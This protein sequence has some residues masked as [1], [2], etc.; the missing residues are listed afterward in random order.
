MSSK[1]IHDSFWMANNH[2]SASQLSTTGTISTASNARVLALANII[3]GTYVATNCLHHLTNSFSS[4]GHP[5]LCSQK[6]ESH[7]LGSGGVRMYQNQMRWNSTIKYSLETSGRDL[8]ISQSSVFFASLPW[9]FQNLNN[10]N[11][12]IFNDSLLFFPRIRRLVRNRSSTFHHQIGRQ[13]K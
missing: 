4:S 12:Q 1:C 3:L 8:P 11:S 5:F 9:H 2:S 6:F 13:V 10:S 7:A